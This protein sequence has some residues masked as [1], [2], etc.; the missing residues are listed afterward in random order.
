MTRD[1]NFERE[2]GLSLELKMTISLFFEEY[3]IFTD[4]LIIGDLTVSSKILKK[5][6]ANKLHDGATIHLPFLQENYSYIL[7]S[8]K[9]EKK[10]KKYRI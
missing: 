10:K 3:Y 2:C 1:Q 5:L 9:N 6:Y 7:I 8:F 4:S